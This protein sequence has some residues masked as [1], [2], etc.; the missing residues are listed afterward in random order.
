[1]SGTVAPR[2]A[3]LVR[4]DD[5]GLVAQAASALVR[6]LCASEDAS[7]VVGTIDAE[8]T[9]PA[10]LVSACATPPMLASRR[11]LVVRE[12]GSLSSASAEALVEYLADPTP[13]T[14]LVL[15]G[16][17][18]AVPPRLVSAVRKAG[19]LVD[20]KLPTGRARSQW[21]AERLAAS[22]VRLDPA[23]TRLVE[24]HLGED[25]ARLASLLDALGA[26]Y[27]SGGRLG[28]A[29][30]EPFLGGLGDAPPWVLTDAIDEGDVGG[31]LTA[32]RRTGGPGGRHPLAIMAVLHR[33]YVQA[34]RLHGAGS[35]DDASAASLLG[36]APF[37]AKKAL[38]LARRLDWAGLSRA[39]TLLAQADLDLR[40]SSALPADAVM[41]VLVARLSRLVRPQGRGHSRVHARDN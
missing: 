26:A 41:D 20:A 32:L 1:M 7:L 38:R 12:A 36:C 35:L 10:S 28:V 40:G 22:A 18:G 34:L 19:E 17:G 24:G 13:T 33:H 8:T 6:S 21:L 9:E 4:G 2:P 30:V 23:A 11:I 14:H 27:A 15:V 25:M 5:P 29:E 37:V 3:Y 16:G 39:T 31:A